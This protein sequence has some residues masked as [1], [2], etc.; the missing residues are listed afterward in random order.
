MNNKPKFSCIFIGSQ[1]RLI[2]CAEIV[3]DKGHTV[4]A[5]VSDDRAVLSWA[6]KQSIEH[7][8]IAADWESKI[9]HQTF[10]YLFSVDNPTILPEAIM[11]QPRCV[12]INF[13]DSPLPKYAGVNATSWA[14]LNGENAHGISWHVMAEQVDAGDILKQVS[15][16]I[17]KRDT[18]FTLNGVCFEKSIE[19]FA[20]LVDELGTNQV[21]QRVPQNIN[22]RSYYKRWQR[23]PVAC[24]IDWRM[25]AIEIDHLIRGLDYGPYKNPMGLPK[26]YLDDRVMI[27]KGCEILET[28]QQ[29]APGSI[30]EVTSESINVSTVTKIVRLNDFYTPQGKPQ[31]PQE[32]LKEM[33]LGVGDVLPA[34]SDDYAE[35]VTELYIKLAKQESFWIDLLTSVEPLRL[36]HFLQTRPQQSNT[37]SKDIRYQTVQSFLSTTNVAGNGDK[38]LT[39]LSI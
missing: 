6:K 26:V 23:P 12:A 8:Q 13:H 2:R 10:D 27:V 31:S 20:D 9:E 14:I 4:Q 30:L 39:A 38:L 24:T 33:G 19:A 3:I 1:S 5:I 21:V 18:T 36:E 11:Q 32:F 22:D 35:A 29:A 16:P 17:Q 15:F 34:L 37:D 28:V 25:T 7:F